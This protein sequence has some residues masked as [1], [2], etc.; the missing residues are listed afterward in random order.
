MNQKTLYFA[1]VAIVT[2][3]VVSGCTMRGDRHEGAAER[4]GRHVDS[5]AAAVRDGAERAGDSV[6]RSGEDLGERVRR[7]DDAD[8]TRERHL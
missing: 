4:A 6:R 2:S 5:A 3:G 1:V 8:D 7:D